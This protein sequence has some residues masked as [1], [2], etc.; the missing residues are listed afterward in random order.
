MEQKL[1]PDG[2]D[3]LSNEVLLQSHRVVVKH[4]KFIA[5]MAVKCR[6]HYTAFSNDHFDRDFAK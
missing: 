4:I 1:Y 6:F 5:K 3:T 2:T